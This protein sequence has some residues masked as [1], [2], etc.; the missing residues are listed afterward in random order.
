VRKELTSV[1][2]GGEVGRVAAAERRRRSVGGMDSGFER[3]RFEI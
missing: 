1:G 2:G 3:G